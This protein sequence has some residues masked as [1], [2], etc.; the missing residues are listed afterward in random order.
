MD[1]EKSDKRGILLKIL[2]SVA[3]LA[4]VATV[5]LMKNG[6]LK[7]QDESTAS[8]TQ[9]ASAAD[10]AEQ[11]ADDFALE[12]ESIDLAALLPYRLPIVIDFGS[13]SCIPCQEMAPVLKSA[14]EDYRG[15]AI[16]NSWMFGNTPTRLQ[17]FPYR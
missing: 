8:P 1:E 5:W 9:S 7:K 12:V 11:S 10:A 2:I 16:V 3:V 6:V 17:V 15:K 14:N 4:A 13:D